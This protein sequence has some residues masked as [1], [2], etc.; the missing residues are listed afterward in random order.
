M[1][2]KSD[3]DKPLLAGRIKPTRRPPAKQLSGPVLRLSHGNE[4]AI[5]S[6]S[7]GPN[8]QALLQNAEQIGNGLHEALGRYGRMVTLL[9]TAGSTV[10]SMQLR[11]AGA[12][13]QRRLDSVLNEIEQVCLQPAADGVQLFD[14]AWSMPLLGS[15]GNIVS[16]I[17]LPQI[18]L[19]SLGSDGVGGRL[20]SVLSGCDNSLEGAGP[21][22]VGAIIR[23]AML[24]IAAERDRLFQLLADIVEPVVAELEVVEANMS[25]MSS[26]TDVDF[27]AA[28]ADI[29]KLTI[30]A[31]RG[32]AGSRP[33]NASQSSHLRLS[34]TDLD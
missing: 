17:S 27:C 26:S 29:S 1:S 15:A 4:R 6:N 14:G 25:A 24:W 23:S 7:S 12:L 3:R 22:T 31:Q 8:I 5:S 11:D 30:M 34:N 10:R 20:I 2:R 32:A 18:S 16:E 33:A 9:E 21:A 28:V 19:A 13:L